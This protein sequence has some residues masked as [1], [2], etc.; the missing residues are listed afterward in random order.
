LTTIIIGALIGWI[1]GKIKNKNEGKKK[2][3]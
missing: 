2:W 3:N 1:V